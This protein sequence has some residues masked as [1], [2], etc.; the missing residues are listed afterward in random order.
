[1]NGK[2]K[3]YTQNPTFSGITFGERLSLKVHGE[4]LMI[5]ALKMLN[6]YFFRI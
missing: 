3:P 5:R 6:I 1:M 4:N 2:H